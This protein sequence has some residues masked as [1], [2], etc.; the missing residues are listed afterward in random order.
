MSE[1]IRV[2]QTPIVEAGRECRAFMVVR[3][4]T[5]R[6]PYVLEYHRSLGIT[7]FFVVD[8]DSSDGA[9]STCC[10]SRIAMFSARQVHTRRRGAVSIG[11]ITLWHAMAIATG[12]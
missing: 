8:N 3:G 7:R 4:E 10:S 1:L 5:L 9:H 2:D 6:L 12:A 11:L